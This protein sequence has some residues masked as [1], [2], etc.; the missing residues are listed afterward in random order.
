[1]HRLYNE[2]IEHLKAENREGS[3]NFVLSK[4]ENNE[5]DIITL[6][7][8]ILAASLNNMKPAENNF[9][10]IW[11]EHVRSSIIRTI[12]EN[13]YTYVIKERD[14]KY[15][16]KIDKKIAV[17][18]P[19]EEYHEIGAR[20]VTDFFT[21]LGYNSIFV[22]SN[23]PKEEFVEAL[24][25]IDLDYIALSISNHYNLVAARK[26]IERIRE[27]NSRVKII[28]GGNAFK[29]TEFCYKV[30]KADMYIETFEDIMR[31]AQE[32]KV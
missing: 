26:A 15:K 16:L 2:F 19:S 6:Y 29:N 24:K 23:T 3:L 27:S 9:A 14:E 25:I 28:V 4:L 10:F 32:D 20:M 13:C 17:V 8:E 30:L 22:G 11:R 18:C 12:I 31:L 7:T 21:L 1:M 5:I